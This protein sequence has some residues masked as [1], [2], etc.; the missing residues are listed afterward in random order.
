MGRVQLNRQ[1]DVYPQII[2][3]IKAITMDLEVMDISTVVAR[4]LLNV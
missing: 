2:P 4:A 1:K 3:Y